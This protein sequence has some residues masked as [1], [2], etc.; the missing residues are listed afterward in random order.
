M[1]YEVNLSQMTLLELLDLYS[2]W[3]IGVIALDLCSSQTLFNYLQVRDN[4]VRS[5][6]TERYVGDLAEPNKTPPNSVPFHPEN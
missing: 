2:E 1:R 3:Q 4:V 6:E 5:L